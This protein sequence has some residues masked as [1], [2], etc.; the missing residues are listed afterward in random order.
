MSFCLE[1]CFF[2]WIPL[3]SQIT[4]VFWQSAQVHF[5]MHVV[6]GLFETHFYW[7][8]PC[9]LFLKDPNLLCKNDFFV[10]SSK[11]TGEQGSML[12]D[13]L[14]LQWILRFVSG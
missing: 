2:G 11:A 6:S 1:A 10:V 13:A 12:R 8:T 9:R 5:V 3:S 14:E 7:D 4:S